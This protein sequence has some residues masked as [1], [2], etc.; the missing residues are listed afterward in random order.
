MCAELG[1]YLKTIARLN[2][3]IQL[4]QMKTPGRSIS[5]WEVMEK[6]RQAI[7]PDEFTTLKIS[8]T[9]LEFIRFEGEVENRSSLKAVIGRLE[10]GTIKLSGFPDNLRV[11]A[12]EAKVPFP[13]RHDWDSFFRDA[14][15]TDEMKPGERPDTV[16]VQGLPCKW[17]ADKRHDADRPSELLVRQAFGGPGPVRRLDI[18]L[19]DPCQKDAESAVVGRISTFS[20]SQDLTFDVYVQYMEYMGFVKAMDSLR[21]MKLMLKTPEGRAFT[22]NIKVDFD[23]SGHLSDESIQRREQE[24]LKL[25]ALEKEREE[26]VLRERLQEERAREAERRRVREEE[27]Q[28]ERRRQE[29]QRRREERRRRQELEEQQEAVQRKR[30][31]EELRKRWEEEEARRKNEEELRKKWEEEEARRKREEEEELKREEAKRKKE[32]EEER[33]K[34]EARRKREEEEVRRREEARRKREEEE[35]QRRQ[36]ARRKRDEEEERRREE[37]RRK[38]GEEAPRKKRREAEHR[39]RPSRGHKRS[40]D[41]KKRKRKKREESPAAAEAE[42]PSRRSAERLLSD[43]QQRALEEEQQRRYLAE[44]Q[45]RLVEQERL[46]EQQ[47]RQQQECAAEATRKLQATHLLQELFNVVRHLLRQEQVLREKLLRNLEAKK[48]QRALEAQMQSGKAVLL[49]QS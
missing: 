3:S 43:Q 23:R 48:R 13:T 46:A 37:A 36:E 20:F 9:T 31:Q 18:P 4:P 6:L 2:V 41:C 34:E 24:R 1:L 33:K 17:F 49:S 5:S 21:G 28:R 38:K 10:N 7:K 30:Y 11:R 47:M 29:R 45:Q 35:E 16:Y 42:G 8:K 26:R 44:Q 19:L 39:Q 22:A 14:K 40:K 15:G 27:E 32:E 25:E 12:A